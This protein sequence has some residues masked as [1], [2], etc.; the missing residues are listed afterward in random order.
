MV[1]TL[2]INFKKL[3]FELP[4]IIFDNLEE[5]IT[6]YLFMIVGID[7]VLPAY[8]NELE[9]RTEDVVQ[10]ASDMLIFNNF[11]INRTSWIDYS[12]LKS[13]LFEKNSYVKDYVEAVDKYLCDLEY[14]ADDIC[15]LNDPDVEGRFEYALLFMR[16][17]FAWLDAMFWYDSYKYN[18]TEWVLNNPQLY[19]NTCIKNAY[20]HLDRILSVYIP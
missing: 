15:P 18:G 1:H 7:S 6:E 19:K 16:D 9:E 4:K 17:I 10:Y 2:Y 5:Y 3:R 8:L 20:R 14:D 11:A 13:K 12:A